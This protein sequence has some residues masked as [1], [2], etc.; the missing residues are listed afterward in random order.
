MAIIKKLTKRGF[1]LIELMIVVVIIGILASLAMYG[2]QRYVANSKSG[3][4]RRMIGRI[5]N[6]VEL[7]KS[8]YSDFAY[9]R[10]Q[11]D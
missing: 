10:F 8:A 1:T 3:E 4:A 7:F 6:D 9:Q 2:V 5:A 11:A